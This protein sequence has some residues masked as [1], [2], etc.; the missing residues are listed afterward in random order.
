MTLALVNGRLLL[1]DDRHCRVRSDAAATA[2]L[3]QG[4]RIA[5]IGDDAEV[6]AA[7][8]GRAEIV[9]L[10]GATVGPGF[11]DAHIHLFGCALDSLEVS[12]LP[13]HAG[14][15]AVIRERL[16]ER[17]TGRADGW[18]LGK[19]YDDMRLLERRHPTRA[20]LDDAVGTRPA[21]VERV[22]GHMCV[23]NT[24]ALALAGIS[25]DTGDPPGGAIVRDAAGLPTGLLLE[26]AQELVRR[27]VPPPDEAEIADAL[28]AAGRALVAHGVTTICEAFLGGHHPREVEIWADVL[29]ADWPGPRVVFLVGDEH[30]EHPSL[31]RLDVPGAKYFADGVVTGRTAAV[32]EPFAHDGGLGMLIHPPDE[33][34]RLVGASAGRG[35]SVGIHAMGDRAIDVSLDALEQAGR[36]RGAFPHR[37]EHCT[38]PS[39]TAIR[40]AAALGIV[41]V[42]QPVFLLAE[43]EAYRAQLGDE[44]VARAYPLRTM[45]AHG[46]RPA[47]SSDAPAT[48]AAAA[49]D[50]WL[51][52]RAAV[53]RTTWAGGSLGAAEAIS[54]AEAVACYTASGGAALGLA[55]RVGALR[56]GAE[57][58][59]VVLPGDPLA[60]PV[61]ELGSLRPQRVFLRG[62]PA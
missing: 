41:P 22:C 19:G 48:S 60:C 3:V 49:F 54:V 11:V 38:L 2:L 52:I 36:P 59:L 32:S 62:R 61:D 57:A 12:L 1:P 34:A 45:L 31:A 44:R 7:A 50:P 15:L 37:I 6:V 13:E 5:A 51:G 9:D 24:A 53:T 14:S 27:L 16:A 10:G 26:R 17:A 46:L 47:L 40:R 28:R 33:L 20:D 21:L 23:V 56:V 4:G 18:I 55:E 35:F 30:R 39:E 42:P 43:G 29:A 25:R 58:D 8:A